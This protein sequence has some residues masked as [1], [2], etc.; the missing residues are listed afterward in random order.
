[1]LAC[2][3]S[4]QSGRPR[5]AAVAAGAKPPWAH[6]S[7]RV[8][9]AHYFNW[10]KTPDVGGSW[11]NW[12][13]K[14]N[15]PQH[16]PNR[17]TPEG[18]R[19][20]CSVYHPL[21]GPYDSSRPEVAE[22]HMLLALA[23]KIDGFCLDWYGIPSD[24]EKGFP[25]LLAQARRLGFKLCIC[26]ED[27]AMFGYSYQARTREEAVENAV[28]NLNYILDTH[29][30]DPAYLRID[31]KPVIVNFSWSE[32][33]E[34]VTNQG[35]SAAEYRRILKNVRRKHDLYFVHDYHCHLREDYWE[36]GDNRYP[37]LDVNGACLDEFYRRAAQQREQGRI[38]FLASLVYP[39]FDNTGVWGWGAGPFITPR[40]D[41]AFYAR[42]WERAITSGVR[43]VQIATWNDFG[44]GATIEPAE[45]YGFKYLGMTEEQA[46]RLK[47]LTSDKGAGLAVPPA[48]YRARLAVNGLRA[49]Q[50]A[51]AAAVERDL[52]GAVDEFLSGRFGPAMERANRV[53]GTCRR[54]A[55]D[56]V[57]P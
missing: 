42:L 45:E 29:A 14:G 55:A 54:T 9:V 50:A 43:F 22:Y 56:P 53:L 24:E 11:K 6:D 1:M 39:G 25:A 4:C 19:D 26:F 18:R 23:S 16:D 57:N 3:T 51:A 49:S 52:N 38:K 20:I 12:E 27:K 41:G 48:I 2:L 46:A 47:G 15:G 13:W 37:W 21:I 5:A 40:E 8:V 44:E 30:K 17:M 36:T 10:F 32:P 31:G 7:D 35:F 28:Q 34:S 33:S